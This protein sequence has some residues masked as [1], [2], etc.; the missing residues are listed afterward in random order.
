MNFFT[1]VTLLAWRPNPQP[2][3]PGYLF[4]SGSSALARQAWEVLPVAYAT[5]GVTLGIV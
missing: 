1:E 2:G 3:G 5:A 4:L